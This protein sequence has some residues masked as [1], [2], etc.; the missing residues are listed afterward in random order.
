M[1]TALLGSGQK[2]T[3]RKLTWMAILMALQI[4]LGKLSFGTSFVQ[5]SPGFIATA[6][7]GYYFGPWWAGL[8]GILTDLLSN[9]LFGITGGGPFFLGFTLSVFV[10]GWLYGLFLYPEHHDWL[11]I[12]L[13]V[14]F[15]TV[16][17]N[18]GLNTLWVHMLYQTPWKVLFGIRLVKDAIVAPI[19]ILILGLVLRAMG[20]LHLSLD[21]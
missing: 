4:V 21:R 3:T 8:A 7:L 9:G 5:V 19:Q 10:G 20:R 16:I 6:L 17:V 1:K 18:I 12:I 15:V 2:L 11:R 13:A 14:L